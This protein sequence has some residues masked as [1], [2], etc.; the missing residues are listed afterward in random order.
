MD[1]TYNV[2]ELGHTQ[3][4]PQVSKVTVAEQIKEFYDAI[5]I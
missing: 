5:I 3:K 2:T 1:K 4:R